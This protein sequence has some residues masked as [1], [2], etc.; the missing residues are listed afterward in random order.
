MQGSSALDGMSISLARRRYSATQSDL[1]MTWAIR[2]TISALILTE[3]CVLL[4]VV[5]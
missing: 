5:L 4:R 1:M 3:Q 2:T